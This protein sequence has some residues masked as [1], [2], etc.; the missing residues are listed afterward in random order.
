MK[1]SEEYNPIIWKSST[2]GSHSITLFSFIFSFKGDVENYILSCV[3]KNEHAIY[4]K[5][6]IFKIKKNNRTLQ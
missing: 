1:F 4:Y 3:K 5:V 6:N 2:L